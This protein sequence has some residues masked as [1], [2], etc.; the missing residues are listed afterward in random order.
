MPKTLLITLYAMAIALIFGCLVSFAALPFTA[1]SSLFG[2]WA[3]NCQ[4]FRR[5]ARW[6]GC[7][8]AAGLFAGL[9][10]YSA[11]DTALPVIRILVAVSSVAT[12]GL[13][14]LALARWNTRQMRGHA[15]AK[16]ARTFVA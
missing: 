11:L 13:L 12:P 6:T 15:L 3:F 14:G 5:R 10:A 2:A 7:S 16:A 9:I 1:L 4:N 8:V